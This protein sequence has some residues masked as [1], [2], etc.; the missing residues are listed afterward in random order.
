MLTKKQLEK[1]QDQ[2]RDIDYLLR[3]YRK[4]HDDCYQNEETKQYAEY[5]R[6]KMEGTQFAESLLS[7]LLKGS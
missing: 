2:L 4:N 7:E 3:K 1:I 5:W 6:G